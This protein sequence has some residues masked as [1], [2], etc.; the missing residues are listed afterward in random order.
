VAV[1][2]AQDGKLHIGVQPEDIERLRLEI[3]AGERRRNATLAAS[4]LGLGGIL[5]LDPGPVISG[6]AHLLIIAAIVTYFI[7]RR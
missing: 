4:V 3:R 2:K 6:L 7:G 5:W 1:Q